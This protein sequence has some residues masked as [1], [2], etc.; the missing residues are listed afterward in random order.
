[1][2]VFVD[3]TMTE[4]DLHA[5]KGEIAEHIVLPHILR[6]GF[7]KAARLAVNSFGRNLNSNI[8][9]DIKSLRDQG[10]SLTIPRVTV[11]TEGVRSV[12]SVGL[13]IGGHGDPCQGL[14]NRL[15]VDQRELAVAPQDGQSAANIAKLRER[16]RLDRQELD[17]CLAR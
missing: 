6:G 8:F 2:N 14:R 11:T 9:G 3:F 10:G 16:V 12:A 7:Q 15:D 1:L 13:M 5:T 17:A 4:A